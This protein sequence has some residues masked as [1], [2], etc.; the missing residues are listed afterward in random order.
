MKIDY[1]ALRNALLVPIAWFFFT[2]VAN[3]DYYRFWEWERGFPLFLAV[4]FGTMLMIIVYSA[5]ASYTMLY[6]DEKTDKDE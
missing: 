5:T 3:N 2:W 6:T 1:K 4:F